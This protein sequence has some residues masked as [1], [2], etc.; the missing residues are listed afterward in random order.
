M[1]FQKTS[2]L[3]EILAQ[4]KLASLQQHSSRIDRLDSLLGFYLDQRLRHMVQVTAYQD[5]TLI[6]AC[7]N[8]TVA[9][10]C[11]YLSRIYMQ[12]LRQHGEFCELKRINA[13]ISPTTPANR[14]RQGQERL[15]RLSPAT[16]ELLQSLSEDLGSGEISEALQRLARHVDTAE[17]GSKDRSS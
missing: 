14:P 5:G 4:G 10:Q 12:Q 11:R 3:T 17:G 15:R 1:R 7:A 13:V 16:A 2:T 9:G 6:L 8:S